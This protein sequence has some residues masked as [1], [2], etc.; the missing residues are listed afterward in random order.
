MVHITITF[1][2]M[3]EP[4]ARESYGGAGDQT[5]P[6]GIEKAASLAHSLEIQFRRGK[7]N[8]VRWESHNNIPVIPAAWRMTRHTPNNNR[9]PVKALWKLICLGSAEQCEMGATDQQ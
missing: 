6:G 7:D 4:I 9:P 1:I 8:P 3:Y 2:V 5:M